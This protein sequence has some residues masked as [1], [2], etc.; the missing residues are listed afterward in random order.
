M[1]NNHYLAHYHSITNFS[2]AIHHTD[3]SIAIKLYPTVDI[4]Y[5]RQIHI[6]QG[7]VTSTFRRCSHQGSQFYNTPLEMY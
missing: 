7:A 2:R 3:S 6:T 5:S 1:T 4:S